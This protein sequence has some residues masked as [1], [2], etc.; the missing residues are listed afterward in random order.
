[1]KLQHI[2]PALF[3]AVS[4]LLVTSEAGNQCA[5]PTWDGNLRVVASKATTASRA[6]AAVLL[7][8][9][10]AEQSLIEPEDGVQP[11]DI[12]CRFPADTYKEVNYYTCTSMALK[13]GITIKKF[14]ELNP[15][16]NPDCSNIQPR[17]VYCVDG[18]KFPRS[19][20]L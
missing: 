17:S 19:V 16:L 8:A 13:Y 18:C 10:R 3:F 1:M 4:A 12:R 9:A 20:W 6:S 11:G 5:P 7:E 15:Q 14:F 2:R